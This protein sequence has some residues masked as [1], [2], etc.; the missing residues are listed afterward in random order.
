MMTGWLLT[1]ITP[2]KE[3]NERRLVTFSHDLD[4]TF[5]GLTP[6]PLLASLWPDEF[7]LS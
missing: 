4:V 2:S 7:F 1:S 3:L 5:D 6:L